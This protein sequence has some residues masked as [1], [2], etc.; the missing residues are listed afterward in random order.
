MLLRMIDGTMFLVSLFY[1]L[2][3]LGKDRRRCL[4]LWQN[5]IVLC[6]HG[7][8]PFPVC[9]CKITTVFVAAQ[10]FVRFF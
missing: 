6:A 8:L 3:S 5:F 2:L 10:A 4:S 9:G 7:K 1:C